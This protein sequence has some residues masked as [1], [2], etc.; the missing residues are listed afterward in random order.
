MTHYRPE[1]SLK[2]PRFTGIPTFARL[3]Y[4]RTIDGAGC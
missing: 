2:S 1:D 4:I 3:P